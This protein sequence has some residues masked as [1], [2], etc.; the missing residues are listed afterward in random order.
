MG[1]ISNLQRPVLYPFFRQP[2]SAILT[3]ASFSMDIP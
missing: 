3:S 1:V 2:L